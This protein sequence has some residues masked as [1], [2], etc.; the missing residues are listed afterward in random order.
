MT[1]MQT[2]KSKWRDL[3]GVSWRGALLALTLA[4]TLRIGF[5]SNRDWRRYRDSTH[6]IEHTYQ[7]LI[8]AE[9]L[10]NSIEHAETGQRG[11]LLTGEEGYLAPYRSAFSRAV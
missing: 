4:V 10:R 1:E 7:V 9:R 6:L 2:A 11:Y 5:T 8:A 3:G